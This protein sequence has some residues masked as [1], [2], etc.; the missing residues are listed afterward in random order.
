MAK[1]MV[2]ITACAKKVHLESR[3]NPAGVSLA[4]AW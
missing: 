4:A 1:A 3:D 2:S